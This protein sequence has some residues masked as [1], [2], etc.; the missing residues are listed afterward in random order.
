LDAAPLACAEA[1]TCGRVLTCDDQM[2][3]T[4]RRVPVAVPVHNP[5]TY[6]VGTNLF[7]PLLRG[8]LGPS[9]IVS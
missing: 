2:L 6:I 4:A 7:D 3:R 9:L 1:A 5:V 8:C